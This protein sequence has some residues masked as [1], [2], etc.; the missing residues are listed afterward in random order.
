MFHVGD[1][2]IYGSNGVCK[3]DKVGPMNL[4]GV[5]RDR[6]YYTLIPVYSKGKQ[7]IYSN[8]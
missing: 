4:D 2:I 6:M 8:R 1:Y 5:S 3:V 7:G